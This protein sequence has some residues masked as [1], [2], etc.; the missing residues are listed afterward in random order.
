MAADEGIVLKRATLSDLDA[1]THLFDGYRV[2]YRKPSDEEGAR[3]FMEERLRSGDSVVFMAV[4]GP[5]TDPQTA[6][7]LGFTQLYPIFSSVRMGRTWLLNDLYVAP[8]ARRRGVGRALL[9][10]AA[11]YALETGALGLELATEK[12]N[13]TAKSVYEDLGWEL[14]TEFDHFSLTVRSSSPHT[15]GGA[16][17]YSDRDE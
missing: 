10:R 6:T 9:R 5:D 17:A 14:D 4:G 1:M 2:F 3:R 13:A 12:D 15:D 7:P 11:E 8:H 16:H